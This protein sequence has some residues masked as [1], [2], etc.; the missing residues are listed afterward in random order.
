MP[1]LTHIGIAFIIQILAPSIPIWALLLATEF[2]DIICIIFYV[3]G[4]EK[5]PTKQEA[6]FAPYSHGLFMAIVWTVIASLITWFISVDLYTTLIIG[7]LVFSHWILDFIA[8][9]MTYVYPNDTGKPIFF[10]NSKKIGLGLWNSKKVV[11]VG[12]YVVPLLGLTLYIIWLVIRAS[13]K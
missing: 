10:Q 5:M 9:P 3:L 8:S 7:G 1:G 12:E 13:I 4:I 6:P 2:L 11:I